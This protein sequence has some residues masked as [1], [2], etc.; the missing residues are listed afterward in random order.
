MKLTFLVIMLQYKKNS[1]LDMK[2]L[3]R[4]LNKLIIEVVKFRD[5]NI[6]HALFICEINR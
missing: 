4:N 1:H 2:V 3:K 6:R 5:L